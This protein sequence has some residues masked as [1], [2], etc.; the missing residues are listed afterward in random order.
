MGAELMGWAHARAMTQQGNLHN[1]PV[2]EMNTDAISRGTVQWLIRERFHH[3]WSG[4]LISCVIKSDAGTHYNATLLPLFTLSNFS[5]Q[6]TVVLDVVTLVDISFV[7]L[8]R[9]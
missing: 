6:I 7:S 8:C 3:L 5:L 9:L 4:H 1:R 2:S